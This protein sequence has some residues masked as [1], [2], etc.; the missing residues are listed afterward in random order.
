MLG[1]EEPASPPPQREIG[2][3]AYGQLFHAVASEFY[4][5]NGESF[6]TREHT[7]A[8]WLSRVEEIAD[9]AFQA[10]LKEYPLVGEAVRAQQRERLRRDVRELIEY[11]WETSQGRDFLFAE[12]IFGRPV[13]VE[14]LLG[15]HS[16]FVRGR[17]DRIDVEGPRTLV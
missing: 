7:L 8:D 6:C 10:F 4:N 14:L 1:F 13:P 16:L 9:H 12:R 17:I 5:R 11:D 15:E 3:P 2:P